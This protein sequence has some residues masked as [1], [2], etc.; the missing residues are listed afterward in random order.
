MFFL[1]N[2]GFVEPIFLNGRYLWLKYSEKHLINTIQ[3]GVLNKPDNGFEAVQKKELSKY[4]SMS[5]IG[6]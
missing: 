5:L 1:I 4:E 3:H 2:I 6:C